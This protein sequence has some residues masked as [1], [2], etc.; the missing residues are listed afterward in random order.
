MIVHAVITHDL[1]DWFSQDYPSFFVNINVDREHA[2]L[3]LMAPT[4]KVI[5]C[6]AI[7][8]DHIAASDTRAVTSG[9]EMSAFAACTNPRLRRWMEKHADELGNL[10][11]TSP[12]YTGQLPLS[13]PSSIDTITQFLENVLAESHGA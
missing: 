5:A 4:S 6:L 1:M 11:Y 9:Q 12:P 10:G 13:D 2:M 3:Y 7:T 8:S